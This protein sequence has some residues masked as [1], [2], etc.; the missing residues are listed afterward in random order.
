MPV[1]K[2]AKLQG[3]KASKKSVKPMAKK[4][5]A[6]KKTAAGKKTAAK[7]TA[8]VKKS[9]GAK[10]P[11]AKSQPVAKSPL[12]VK[13][14]TAAAPAPVVKKAEPKPMKAVA[15]MQAV[16]KDLN[17]A[18]D[19]TLK[20]VVDKA[21]KMVKQAKE[22]MEKPAV[23]AAIVEETTTMEEV[24]LAA[25]P[26][27]KRMTKT[28]AAA[29]EKLGKMTQKWMALYRRAKTIKSSPY[30]MR[31]TYEAKTAIEHK[32][33]GW[34][35]ILTNKNDRLEVLFKDGVKFLISNYK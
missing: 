4:A 3:T 22:Q 19:K 18:K 29:M 5:V 32:I 21:K 9:A 13:K 25:K 33:L 26:V 11:A 28:Q 31:S 24:A 12:A 2:A 1:K 20:A 10:K 7:K 8:P 15:T 16:A 23:L 35:Y 27:K 6:E 17:A 14:P 30:S 34:G